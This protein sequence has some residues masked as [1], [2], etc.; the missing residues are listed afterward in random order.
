MT[1]VNDITE[2]LRQIKDTRLITKN[3]V[4]DYSQQLS[5]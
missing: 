2:M 3:D 4:Q 1:R 5:N